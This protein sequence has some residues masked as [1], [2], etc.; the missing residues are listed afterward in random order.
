M[1]PQ[2]VACGYAS[3]FLWKFAHHAW[4]GNQ[5]GLVYGFL[6]VFASGRG[7]A[8]I[9]NLAVFLYTGLMHQHTERRLL[10]KLFEYI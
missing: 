5:T 9:R 7:F 1:G 3:G 8:F 2:R 6:T 4:H 10:R